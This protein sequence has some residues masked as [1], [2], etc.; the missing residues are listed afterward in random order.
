MEN[1]D[2]EIIN[3]KEA[4]NME[5]IIDS[6]K[7]VTRSKKC[8]GDNTPSICLATNSIKANNYLIVRNRDS[9]Y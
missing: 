5:I 1:V 3:Q 6:T 8:D 2:K 9:K 4:S 7:V